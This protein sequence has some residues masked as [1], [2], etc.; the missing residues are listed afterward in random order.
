MKWSLEDAGLGTD[1]VDYINAHGT[2]TKLNDK[3]ESQAIRSVTLPGRGTEP[4]RNELLETYDDAVRRRVLQQSGVPGRRSGA[5]LGDDRVQP[6]RFSN[7]N[8]HQSLTGFIGLQILPE[9]LHC[10]GK[11]TCEG[12]PSVGSF[13]E[14]S[15]NE[16]TG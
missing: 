7:R 4:T 11:R 6:R 13:G 10:A 16:K 5:D 1:S 12:I 14:N 8:L 15:E 9:H 3:I 2:S